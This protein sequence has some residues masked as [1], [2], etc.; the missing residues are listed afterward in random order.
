MGKNASWKAGWRQLPA[1]K[2]LYFSGS[3]N[4]IFYFILFR[5]YIK[6]TRQKKQMLIFLKQGGSFHCAKFIKAKKKKI[7]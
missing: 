3:I 5:V 6:K 4:E 1:L 7:R 2:M